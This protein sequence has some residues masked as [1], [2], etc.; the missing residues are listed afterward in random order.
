MNMKFV[1]YN[2]M[3]WKEKSSY[4]RLLCNGFDPVGTLLFSDVK[5]SLDCPVAGAS[6]G[7]RKTRWLAK[8]RPGRRAAGMVTGVKN[9]RTAVKRA[10][11]RWFIAEKF[12]KQFA[13]WPKALG[14]LY[15]DRFGPMSHYAFTYNVDTWIFGL[16]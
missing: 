2:H 14:H 7:G 8:E 11:W 16:H 4:Y 6:L 10:R 12:G 9:R 1:A 15:M 5:Y 13:L 3:K